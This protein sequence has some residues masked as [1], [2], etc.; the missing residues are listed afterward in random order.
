MLGSVRSPNR[1]KV[2]ITLRVMSP[3]VAITLRV[4]SPTVAITL[5]VRGLITRSVMATM[6]QPLTRATLKIDPTGVRW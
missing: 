3:T 1:K 4:M 6:L 5:R 2:A